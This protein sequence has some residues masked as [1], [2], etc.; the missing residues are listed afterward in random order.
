[1]IK[2]LCLAVLVTA[3]VVCI[4]WMV[5]ADQEVI[6]KLGFWTL[7]II[8]GLPAS[9][10]LADAKN[11]TRYEDC[12]AVFAKSFVF[13]AVIGGGIWYFAANNVFLFISLEIL[14]WFV[15]VNGFAVIALK[16]G[17]HSKVSELWKIGCGTVMVLLLLIY[18]I[19][20][21]D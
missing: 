20:F 10:L 15:L 18:T 17:A 2:S 7:L 3:F 9:A 1:M 21:Q 14:V 5:G 12:K 8:A 4:A 13:V 6:G 16:H 11:C 19:A